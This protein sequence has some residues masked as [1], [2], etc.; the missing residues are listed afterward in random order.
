MTGR[1]DEGLT[2]GRTVWCV[3]TRQHMTSKK[4]QDI[5]SKEK[6]KKDEIRRKSKK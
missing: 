4:G 1:R 2:T 3:S 5:S 6:P